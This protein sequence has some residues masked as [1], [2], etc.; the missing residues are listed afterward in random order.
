MTFITPTRAFDPEKKRIAYDI[1]HGSNMQLENLKKWRQEVYQL[2]WF[3]NGA[4]RS[5]VEIN[6]ILIE[7]DAAST[8]QS[9][10]FFTSAVELVQLILSM[11]PGSLNTEDWYPKYEYTVDE[12]GQIRMLEPDLGG[13]D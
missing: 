3:N 13:G 7:M 6:D 12:N 11:D 9:G 5:W 4:L 1:L 8:G 2:F 10:Q